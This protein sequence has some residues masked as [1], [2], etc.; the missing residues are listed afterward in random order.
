MSLDRELILLLMQRLHA[1]GILDQADIDSMARN[2][3]LGHPRGDISS[4][5]DDMGLDERDLTVTALLAIPFATATLRD[6]PEHPETV[7][8]RRQMR[9]RTAHIERIKGE[10][11]PP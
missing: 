9:L 10:S 6:P 8:R 11:D 4:V 2:V 5:A 1:K 3:E 7:F